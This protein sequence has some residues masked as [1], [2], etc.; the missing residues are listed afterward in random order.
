MEPAYRYEKRVLKLLQWRTGAKVWRLKCPTH[1][2]F[3]DAYVRVFGEA[4]F[5]QTHRDVSKVLPS[6]CD[7]Y[8]TL[9]TDANPGIDPLYVGELN[10]EQWSIAMD[11]LLAFRRDPDN[12]AR[13]FDIGFTEFQA[14]PIGQIRRL[15]EWLGDELTQ[16]TV[17]RMLAWR[18]RRPQGQARRPHLRRRPVRHHRSGPGPALRPVSRPLRP[19]ACIGLG[20]DPGIE[21]A[22]C[23]LQDARSRC[24]RVSVRVRK[25][26]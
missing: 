23:C 22:T 4:R 21:P 10:M 1:T 6:V 5:W 20:H 15:Y 19:A 14:D 9:L 7:L 25:C 18:G 13:F 12:D 26:L 24:R 2:M 16:A 11:R 3:L 8:Y 17:D